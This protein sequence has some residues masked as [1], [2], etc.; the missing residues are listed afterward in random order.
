M[1]VQLE[2]RHL[3]LVWKC[4]QDQAA[5]YGVTGVTIWACL[6]AVRPGNLEVS[7][8]TPTSSVYQII[9]ESN[10]SPSVQQLKLSQN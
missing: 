9:L 4:Y 3:W 5:K 7:E 8:L 2:K 6:A 10:V 1:A